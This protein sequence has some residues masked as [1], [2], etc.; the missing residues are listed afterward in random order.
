[1]YVFWGFISSL[2]V[3]A[4]RVLPHILKDIGERKLRNFGF[5]LV[6]DPHLLKSLPIIEC[7]CVYIFLLHKINLFVFYILKSRILA[8]YKGCN[9][10]IIYDYIWFLTTLLTINFYFILLNLVVRLVVSCFWLKNL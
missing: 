5:I 8:K 6:T 10:S 4:Y 7:L 3:F 9:P 1:M 2:M